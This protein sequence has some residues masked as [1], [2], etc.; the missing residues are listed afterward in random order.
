MTCMA[1]LLLFVCTG[2][3]C[4]SPMAAEI[5]RLAL[6]KSSPWRVVSAGLS[7]YEGAGASEFAIAAMRDIGG[8]LTPHRSQPVTPGLVQQ[9][10]AIVVMTAAHQKTFLGRFPEAREKLFLLR[11]FDPQAPAGSDVADPFC[12][13]F[14]EYR[15]CRDVIRQAIPGLVQFLTHPAPSV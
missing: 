12:G 15:D 14:H 2:N 7:A 13:S 4:R 9:A 10:A 8:D 1:P 5:L 11:S 6:P 3:I